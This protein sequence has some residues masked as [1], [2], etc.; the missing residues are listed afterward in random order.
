MSTTLLTSLWDYVRR[1]SE[2]ERGF[3]IRS[4]VRNLNFSVEIGNNYPAAV[5]RSVTPRKRQ[6][7]SKF[8][9]TALFST[10]VITFSQ[11]IGRNL[12][13][14]KW[15]FQLRSEICPPFDR[16]ELRIFTALIQHHHSPEKLDFVWQR[17][18]SCRSGCR[19]REMERNWFHVIPQ[20]ISKR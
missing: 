19:E 16:S 10:P 9:R 3:R 17:W 15:G 13:K 18:D 7:V 20:L 1:E 4:S 5:L 14:P 6:G 11:L 12:C 2:R 8:L